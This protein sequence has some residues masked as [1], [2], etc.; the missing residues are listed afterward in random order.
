MRNKFAGTCTRCGK[1]VPPE[2]GLLSFVGY[3]EKKMWPAYRFTRNVSIIQHDE[4]A[5]RY[6][7]TNTHWQFFPIKEQ[8]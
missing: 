1:P 6:T 4:C 7:G 8:P 3:D 2:G 5:A